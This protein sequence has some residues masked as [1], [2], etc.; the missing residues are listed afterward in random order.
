MQAIELIRKQRNAQP[1]STAEIDWLVEQ[2]TREQIPDYQMSAWLMAV[3]LRGLDARATSDLTLAMARSGLE[4]HV[5]ETI[6]PVVDKHST[7]GVGDK[8]TLAVAPL[9]AACG[10]AVGKMTGRGLGHTGGTVDK[11]ESVRGFRSELSREEFMQTLL[12]HHIVL[13]GQSPE[14]APADG[15]MYALRD[16]T[17]TVESIPLIAASIMSKK[18]A[19]G[20]SHLLL[21]VKFGKGAFM[22]NVEQARELAT[23]MV[24]IGRAAGIHTVAAITAMEQPLGRAVG[25]ALEMAEAIAI[26]RGEGPA[27]VGYLCYHEAAELLMMTGKAANEQAA[28]QLVEQAVRSGAAVAKLAEV[29][30]AQ[31]GDARQIEQPELLPTAPVRALLMAPRSGY[32]AGIQAEQLGLA[33]M[34]LGAGRFKKGEAIDH[35]TGFILQAKVGDKLEAG[36]ALV[37]I[38]ARNE[39][40]AEAVREELLRCF[41]WS[42]SP[43]KPGALIYD[44]I[45]P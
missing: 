43:V 35:R 3:C 10:I 18:L 19:I 25:N 37:E 16:V 13:A 20:G 34:R 41:S 24:E 1:L 11:L 17:A 27:D 21:D 4:L 15:K 44:V 36:Q 14:L 12:Q 28:E 26:L 31:G 45:R 42:D 38:H 30:A 6:S 39:G 9:V 7:G 23:L 40:E 2:Y 5:R 8:V 22:K 29:I 33:S 32:L